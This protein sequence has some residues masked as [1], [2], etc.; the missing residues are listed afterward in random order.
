MAQTDQQGDLLAPGTPVAL[1]DIPAAHLHQVVLEGT[2]SGVLTD[3]PGHRRDTPLPGQ[4]GT[5]VLMGRAA[6]YGGPSAAST[7]SPRATRSP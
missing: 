2:D 5:S 1:I 3:G 7:D 6:A 4:S